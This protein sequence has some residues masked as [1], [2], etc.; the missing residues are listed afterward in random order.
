MRVAI[1]TESFLPTLN[2]VTTSVCRILDCLRAAGHQALVV[3]PGPAPASYAGFEVHTVMGVTV[4]QFR[5]GLPSYDLE[6]VLRDFRPDVVHAASPFGLGARGLAAARNLRI[7]AVAI[8]QT[9][10]PSYLR[11]HGGPAAGFVERAA[12]RWIRHMHT[13]ADLTLVPSS[14]T[15][16]ELSAHGVPRTALWRRG[17]DTVLFDPARRYDPAVQDLR[18]L[19]APHDETIVGYV[20]R[21]APEKEVHR[22]AEVADLPGVSLCVVG[23]GPSRAALERQL[24][25]ASFLGYRSGL[26]LAQAYAA[27]DV[28]AHTGTKETFGQTLQEAMAAGLPVVAPAAGGPLDIVRPGVTGLLFDPDHPGTLRQAVG[29]LVADPAMRTRMGEAARSRVADRS[30]SSLVDELV[31]Y[32]ASVIAP[33]WATP[34]PAA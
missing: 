10:M 17:V 26:P 4:R 11:Q 8:Y 2:G 33:S 14:Q 18:E 34:A 24:P 22:L 19:L 7:P 21:L 23:D 32:Y 29:G 3:C 12:W 25:R 30:W 6:R 5:V 1:V 27:L 28:F 20:G 15:L 16:Q 9:D 31:A 13:L